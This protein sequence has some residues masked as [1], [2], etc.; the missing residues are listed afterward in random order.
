M[1]IKEREGSDKR[2]ETNGSRKSLRAS[3]RIF[4]HNMKII[5]EE[6]L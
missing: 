6:A 2:E 4:N 1:E 5:K 3:Y